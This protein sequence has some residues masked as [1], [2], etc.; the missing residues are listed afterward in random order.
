M[1]R[2]AF[3][4]RQSAR[5]KGL[6]GRLLVRIMARETSAF[7]EEVLAALQPRAEERILEVGFGH[8]RTLAVVAG[9]APDARFSGIDVSADAARVASRRCRRL[10][11]AGRVELRVGDSAVLPWEPGAF[12]RAFSVHTLY[13]WQEP[14]RDL[15]EIRRVL[16]RGGTFVLGFRIDSPSA[17]ASFPPPTYRFYSEEEVTGLIRAAGFE[18]IELRPAAGT[19]LR[20]AVAG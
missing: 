17:V 14:A 7:N 2:P 18:N 16:R 15:R 19:D 8:G 10:I 5:P 11:D 9:R 1:R 3:I 4:A 20:I 6:V 12:D 13:F